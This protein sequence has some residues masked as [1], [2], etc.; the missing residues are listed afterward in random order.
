MFA[1]SHTLAGAV[2]L[3]CVT[4]TEVNTFH[5][6]LPARVGA[7]NPRS[8]AANRGRYPDSLVDQSDAGR[9]SFT[10]PGKPVPGVLVTDFADGSEWALRQLLAKRLDVVVAED[11]FA[12]SANESNVAAA[13]GDVGRHRLRAAAVAGGDDNRVNNRGIE[14]QQLSRG[15]DVLVVLAKWGLELIGVAVDLLGPPGLRFAAEDPA[16]RVLGLDDDHAVRRDDDM[17]DLRRV[18]GGMR[19]E[20]ATRRD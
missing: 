5:Q 19:G 8:K 4:D 20:G 16:L 1:A 11:A 2:G 14:F 3:R 9:T 13:V 12:E 7:I 6:I 18:V 10:V 17:M 15:L